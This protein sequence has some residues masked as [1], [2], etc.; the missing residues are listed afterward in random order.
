MIHLTEEFH[1]KLFCQNVYNS[2]MQQ[3]FG[4]L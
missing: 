2:Q 3:I 1:P 4:Y